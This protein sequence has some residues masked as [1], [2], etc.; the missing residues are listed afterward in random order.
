MTCIRWMRPRIHNY[1]ASTGTGLVLGHATTVVRLALAR[2]LHQK[3]Q[4]SL[5]SRGN[6]GATHVCGM[7]LILAIVAVACVLVTGAASPLRAALSI[8][9]ASV[10]PEFSYVKR[11]MTHWQLVWQVQ[12]FPIVLCGCCLVSV[13]VRWEEG[14][15]GS[16]VLYA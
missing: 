5:S 1:R 12:S 4:M 13:V 10:S 11:E 7:L 15:G 2:A 3:E 8:N 16:R 6:S 14:F 9:G